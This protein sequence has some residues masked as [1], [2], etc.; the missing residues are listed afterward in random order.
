MLGIDIV[1]IARVEKIYQ[2]HGN[3]FLE[4]IL[5]APEIKQLDRS[6]NKQFFKNLSCYIAC[7][8]AIFKACSS[9]QLDWREICI[10]NIELKPRILINRPNFKKRI[11][12]SFTASKNTVLSQA[13]I[14]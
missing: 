9:D 6:K 11:S 10:E 4:K 8:E 2:K 1:D 5:T 7:K 3:L 14:K 13:L 12:L